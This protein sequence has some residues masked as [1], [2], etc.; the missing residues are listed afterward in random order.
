MGKL[1]LHGILPP[2]MILSPLALVCAPIVCEL[3][4]TSTASELT[5]YPSR[6]ITTW[7]GRQHVQT[8]QS[9]SSVRWT[10]RITKGLLAWSRSLPELPLRHSCTRENRP[11]QEED[12]GNFYKHRLERDPAATGYPLLVIIRRPKWPAHSDLGAGLRE[13]WNER[14][15]RP[16]I[17]AKLPSYM[18]FNTRAIPA[19]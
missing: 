3:D 6:W 2:H 10:H 18:A 8:S 5:T 4:C 16:D 7:A 19:S 15:Q 12:W 13:D 9:D 1:G 14:Y 11:S 17:T